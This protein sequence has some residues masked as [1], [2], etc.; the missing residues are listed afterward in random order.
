M[1]EKPMHEELRCQE[2]MA[3]NAV[4]ERTMRGESP[5]A[6]SRS[7]F[8]TARGVLSIAAGLAA[9]TA[10]LAA[11]AQFVEPDVRVIRLFE[12]DQVGDAF[13]WVCANLSDL[14][15]D[16]VDDIA[17]PAISRNASAGRVSILSGADGGLLGQVDGA[18]G[19][20]RGF[21]AEAAGDVDGDCVPDYIVGGARVEVY[22]G[23]DH[24]LLLDLTPTTA[25]GHS[26]HGAGD[27]DGDGLGDLLVGRQ[28]ASFSFPGAGRVWALSGADGSILWTRDGAAAG[29]QLGSAI[30]SVGDV[31]RDRVPDVVAGAFGAGPAFGGEAYLLDGSDGSILHVLE[32]V[33]PQIA[34]FFGQFFASGAGDMNADGVGDVFVGD[35]GAGAAGASHGTATIYSGRTGR[36]LHHLVGFHPGDGL[37]P[38]RGISDVNGD[39]F[40]DIFVAAYLNSEGAPAAG[41]AYLFSGRSGALL[42][43]MTANVAGDLFGVDAMAVGDTDGDG[44]T[45]FLVTAVGLSFAQLD[46][47]RAYLIAGTVLPCPSDLTGNRRV[48][49]RDATLLVHRIL[50]ADPAG[51]L[52][53]DGVADF[54]DLA[55]LLRDVGRCPSGRPSR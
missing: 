43:T 1:R 21:S 35:Y 55:V 46:V 18:P 50:H 27:L 41:K 12:G 34:L 23:A 47:G 3:E 14:D 17:I 2:P 25:F 24:S 4:R 28:G 48:D 15:G 30:G 6:W 5:A 44:L 31:N 40:G 32:P 51:D 16:G 7:R 33:D 29:Q 26:V 10:P 38:G 42:R 39:R 9:G 49:A 54:D 36:V 11:R 53:G 8:R 52:D 19:Q 37:G 22:S 13:G 20:S 45:D